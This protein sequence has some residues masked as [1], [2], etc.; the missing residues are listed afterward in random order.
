MAFRIEVEK[1][2]NDRPITPVPNKSE[3]LS[4]LIRNILYF[5]NV[6]LDPC[7]S[8][9]DDGNP[10]DIKLDGNKV[11]DQ[12]YKR[13]IQEYFSRLQKSQKW[14]KHKPNFQVG[15][16][17][18]VTSKDTSCG[19]RQC[20]QSSGSHRF[21]HLSS[22]YPNVMYIHVGRTRVER[23]IF[24]SLSRCMYI[25]NVDFHDQDK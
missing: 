1:I 23:R 5:S 16:L 11:A 19:K 18:L 20:T 12:F 24:T 9:G 6:T 14:L 4:A 22:R 7:V 3:D 15:D 2:I 21:R 25:C 8:S 10:D 17:V 13:W